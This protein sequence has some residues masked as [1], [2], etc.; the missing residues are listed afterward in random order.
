[1]NSRIDKHW[2]E[3]DRQGGNGVEQT[4]RR[5]KRKSWE[6]ARYHAHFCRQIAMWGPERRENK[7]SNVA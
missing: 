7:W 3:M 1:M 2:A 5:F 4:H 6:Q